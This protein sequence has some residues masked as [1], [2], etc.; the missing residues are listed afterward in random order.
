MKKTLIT[1]VALLVCLNANATQKLPLEP[2][3]IWK[4]GA[5]LD[6]I[7]DG[8]SSIQ[9][10][11]DNQR[12]EIAKAKIEKRS[13]NEFILNQRRLQERWCMVEARCISNSIGEQQNEELLVSD[14]FSSCLA[15]LSQH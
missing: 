14:R 2:E 11:F 3:R 7:V 6:C 15:L 1:C 5:V 8:T 12:R 13:F 9:S 10:E 4:Q